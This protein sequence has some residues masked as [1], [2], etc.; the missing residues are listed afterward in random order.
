MTKDLRL[1]VSYDAANTTA[2]EPRSRRGE[3]SVLKKFAALFKR[4][5]ARSNGE[6]APAPA[7]ASAPS[8]ERN[9]DV[10]VDDACSTDSEC[11]DVRLEWLEAYADSTFSNCDSLPRSSSAPSR[12][13]FDARAMLEEVCQSSTPSRSKSGAGA[14]GWRNPFLPFPSGHDLA[15]FDE[16]LEDVTPAKAA[17]HPCH[18]SIHKWLDSTS[19]FVAV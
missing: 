12:T 10:D 4:A 15:S 14:V 3:P 17:A 7:P 19:H 5:H 1:S 2:G 13:G 18:A 8:P 6:V 11:H 16:R 9:A